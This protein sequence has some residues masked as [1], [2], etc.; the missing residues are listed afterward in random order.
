M[1]SLTKT[2][3][4]DFDH[5]T[6]SNEI[7]TR[8]AQSVRCKKILITGV[9]PGGLGAELARSLAYWKPELLILTGRDLSK[10]RK[11]SDTLQSIMVRCVP[12]ELDLTSFDSIK[13]AVNF[14]TSQKPRRVSIDIMIN[15]AGVMGIRT[16]KLSPEGFEMHLATNYLGPFLFT[17]SL[18]N[19]GAF[20]EKARIVNVGGNGDWPSPFRFADYNYD[21]KP[22]PMEEKPI[23]DLCIKYNLPWSDGYT[24]MSAY[25]QSKTAVM[26]WTVHL[27]KRFAHKGIS[28]VCVT[29][30]WTDTYIWRHIPEK[31]AMRFFKKWPPS[32]TPARSVG[33][34]LV[35]ALDPK[36]ADSP[37]A[38][39]DSSY[40]VTSAVD[41]ATDEILAEK[42]WSLSEELTTKGNKEALS[43]PVVPS[44]SQ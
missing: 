43:A 5:N 39:I 8:F 40:Q 44:N 38:L 17:L 29:P 36:L 25:G 16:R 32:M 21:G 19:R 7:V 30:P 3:Y 2:T 23:E 27:A 31:W 35:G 20:S 42:L 14:I 1:S 13:N 33:A 15:N 28:A 4:Q 26:L 24:P 10:V 18:L 11:I 9:G 37:G 6:E 22:L 34:I 12:L 41:Y